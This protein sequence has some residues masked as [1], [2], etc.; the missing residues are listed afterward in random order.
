LARR[1]GAGRIRSP[2]AP[3]WTGKPWFYP[4]APAVGAGHR[5]ALARRE[6]G[7]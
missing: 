7:G 2:A 1:R 5:A 4:V 3:A 6:G